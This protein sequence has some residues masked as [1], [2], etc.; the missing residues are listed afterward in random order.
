MINI[1]I[2][3]LLILHTLCSTQLPSYISPTDYLTPAEWERGFW[4]T[5]SIPSSSP[6]ITGTLSLPCA[7]SPNPPEPIW[8][9]AQWGTRYPLS[10]GQ[11]QLTEKRWTS[12][13]S[14]KTI[15]LWRENQHTHLILRCNGIVE[16]GGKIRTYGEP[17]PHLL[18]EK[19]FP[20]E[21]SLTRQNLIF[22][23]EFRINRCQADPQL[24]Q[25]LDP[26][27]HTAQVSAYWTVKNGN[28]NSQDYGNYFWFG[29]PLFDV[30]YPIPGEYYHLDVG[31]P[32]ATHKFI[33]VVDGKQ[34]WTDATGDGQWKHLRLNI[35][36][37]IYKSLTKA[38]E[39]GYLIHTQTA[40]LFLTSFNLGWELPGPYDTELELR[41]LSLTPTK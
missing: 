11:F 21:I 22:E 23:I 8:R 1:Y 5:S 19:I 32:Y 4:I 24:I 30:R 31:S 9:M 7:T 33:A 15:I 36:P 41:K 3:S 39:Q 35:I 12:S 37:H 28:K 26:Q 6:N 20:E 13:N 25:Q 10:P 14:G 2:F 27:L 16:Y 38:Q 40:D 34:L 17:W 29:V 18:V